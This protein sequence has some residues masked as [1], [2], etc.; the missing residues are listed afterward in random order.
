MSSTLFRRA[1]LA[2]AVLGLLAAIY[3]GYRYYRYFMTHVSTD[4]AYVDG[5][6]AL[7]S[8]RVEGTVSAVY[9]EDNWTVAEGDLLVTLDPRD[10][11]VRVQ[12]ARAQLD[13]ARQTVEEQYA[14]VSSAEAGLQ[15]AQSQLKQARA[16]FERAKQLKDSGVVSGQYYDQAEI[17]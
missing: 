4:D 7:V 17:A 14:Q 6:L 11:E 15:L 16:D 12:Q 5:T 3:P 8:A 9:V 13:R 1:A 10:Y 2:I